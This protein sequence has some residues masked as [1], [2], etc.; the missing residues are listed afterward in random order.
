MT[1][2]DASSATR[3]PETLR[4]E[5]GEVS[6]VAVTVYNADLALVKE[7]RKFN[8]T[9]GVNY[10]TLTGVPSR[11]DATSVHFKPLGGEVTLLEQNYDYDL[12]SRAKLLQKYI[13]ATITVIGED[14]SRMQGKLLSVRDGTV[15]DCGGKVLLNPPGYFELPSLPGGLLL[16]PTL[17][18]M[19]KSPKALETRAEVSYT[20]SGLS[21]SAD[22]ILVLNDNDDCADLE[23]WVTMTNNSGASFE[24]ARLKLVAG[25]IHRA[26]APMHEMGAEVAQALRAHPRGFEEEAF[27]EYHLYTLE[28]PATILDAQ[29]KQLSLL[30]GSDVKVGKT[31]VF[32]GQGAVRAFLEIENTEENGLGIPL[33]AGRFRVFKRD[34]EGSLHMV[35]ED[36][37]DHT[38]KGELVELELGNSFDIKGEKRRIAYT[39]FKNGYRATYEIVIRNQK[40]EDIKI[41]VPQLLERGANWSMIEHSH[42]YEIVVDSGL[43]FALS[44]PAN[45]ETKLTYTY[46]CWYEL[47][48]EIEGKPKKKAKKRTTDKTK[49]KS[50]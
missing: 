11:I 46:K 49:T 15:I 4:Q 36:G 19:L 24:S 8:L 13:G 37:I 33:P 12:V 30:E 10:V 14:G 44:V 2:S 47:K 39:D 45:G 22:Y 21:W 6:S 34:R 32:R 48:K 9:K 18:W 3:R 40:P 35:G 7:A 1:K 25:D 31:Y 42:P 43:L 29:T 27:F 50:K 5:A 20:T 41:S 16:C 26:P 17:E 28:R 23:G 38:A